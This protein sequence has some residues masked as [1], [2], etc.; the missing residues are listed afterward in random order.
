LTILYCFVPCILKIIALLTLN[1]G[2][3][4]RNKN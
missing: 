3:I 4:E 2:P 1:F